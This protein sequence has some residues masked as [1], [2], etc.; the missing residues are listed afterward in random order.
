MFLSSRSGGLTL[1]QRV[2]YH[3]IYQVRPFLGNLHEGLFVGGNIFHSDNF[4]GVHFALGIQHGIGSYCG[5]LPQPS[6][7][8]LVLLHQFS[9]YFVPACTRLQQPDRR[10]FL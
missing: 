7:A 8:K 1:G 3:A 4:S 5:I 6:I 9:E 2:K 10:N